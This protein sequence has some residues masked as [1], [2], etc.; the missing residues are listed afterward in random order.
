MANFWATTLN[1]PLA[2]AMVLLIVVTIAIAIGVRFLL[3]FISNR[4]ILSIVEGVRRRERKAENHS[5]NGLKLIP[6]NA[7]AKQRARTMGSVINNSITWIIVIVT[8]MVVL[9]ELG[10]SVVAIAASAGVATAVIGFGAQNVIKDILNGLFLV[11]EDQFGVGDQVD[12]GLATGT[13]EEVGV[14]IT[15]VR[16]A[17]GVLWFVRNGEIVRVGNLSQAKHPKKK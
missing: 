12:L 6:L 3:V 14:R 10:V 1:I 4:T 9:Q 16:D 17:N 8:F 5:A 15:K 2:L 7:R 11:F 13:I